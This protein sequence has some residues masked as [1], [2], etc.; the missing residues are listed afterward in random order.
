M[1]FFDSI[2]LAAVV[3]ELNSLGEARIDKVGQPSAHELYLNVRAGGQNH[4]LY[5][6]VREQ[7]ARIHL[8]ERQF[9]N[10]PVPFAFTM[11]L[12]KHLEGSRLLRVEQDGLERVVRLVVAGRDE[13]GDPYERHLVAE[14]IGKYSNLFLVDSH[15]EQ[16]LGC[17]RSVTEEMCQARQLAPGLPYASPPVAEDKVSFLEATEAD[18]CRALEEDGAVV[19]RLSRKLT[20]V[21]KVA[22]AQILQGLGIDPAV[23]VGELTGLQPLLA[24]LHQAQARVRSGCFHPRLEA[25]PLWHYNMLWL[26]PGEPPA[27]PG[28]SA[29]L[30]AYYGR[31]E[32]RFQLADKRRVLTSEIQQL[33]KKQRDRLKEWESTLTKSEGADRHRELGDLITSHMY[34]ITPGMSELVATDYYAEGQPEVRV[35]LDPTLTA[36]ENAQRYFRRYQKARNSR[37]AVERLLGE[38]RQEL[39]YLEQVETAIAQAETPRELA[40]IAEELAALTG[41]APAKAKGP[42]RGQSPEPPPAPTAYTSSDGLTILVGKNNKQNEQLT[43]KVARPFDLWLHTQNIP[44]S[45]VVIVSDGEVPE[46]TLHEAATLAAHYSK[47]RESSRVPVIYTRRKFV[48]KPKGAKPGMV[49]YEQEKTLFVTPDPEV[50]AALEAGTKLQSLVPGP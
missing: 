23:S 28:P 49:I 18:F 50:I 14:L 37:E 36:G 34:M 39:G 35:P 20:G 31:E 11:L 27:G 38:G 45:H 48:K 42:R 26:A 1:Q 22:L 40:E 15:S 47:A 6:N 30:D 29:V 9:P 25:G 33:L 8:T 32:N 7:W 5:L 2:A 3:H 13:L 21:S 12:R 24:G 46:R 41:K 16:L 44:G 4:R 43:F 17:L 10:L 19:D